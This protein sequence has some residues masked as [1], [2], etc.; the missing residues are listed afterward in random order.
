MSI[1]KN[2]ATGV[3]KSSIYCLCVISVLLFQNTGALHAAETGKKPSKPTVNLADLDMTIP[4]LRG[5][6]LRGALDPLGVNVYY[7]EQLGPSLYK[8]RYINIV[9]EP[10][11]ISEKPGIKFTAFSVLRGEGIK[12]DWILPDDRTLENLSDESVTRVVSV[13]LRD[14]R[15]ETAAKMLDFSLDENDTRLLGA[16][17][18]ENEDG[19]YFSGYSVEVDSLPARPRFWRAFG[20]LLAINILGEIQYYTNLDANT[21]D[22]KYRPTWN[23][24]RKKLA[25]GPSLDAN[26]FTTNAVGHLY[27]GNMYFN[28]AR[29]NGYD[30]FP[31]MLFSLS[32]SLMWEYLGEF[33]EQAS[34]NDLIFTGIGG[35]LLG[36]G[37]T[38]TCNYIEKNFRKSFLR[39][40]V[41]LVINPLRV[42]NRYIDHTYNDTYTLN[43][44]FI[45][46]AQAAV[47]KMVR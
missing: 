37:L 27:S 8:D 18:G 23:G 2:I 34:A 44:I 24:V 42:L 35:A 40:A 11:V 6:F 47:D 19:H 12:I 29:T 14:N 38:Q 1:L 4:V 30:F 13:L 31:S 21:D 33:K 32:G 16:V 15:P 39:D 10:A 7:P 9:S 20:E 26:N 5:V 28:A 45:N 22:W 46:P 36:E 41:V 3:I 17:Y 43:I 25:D